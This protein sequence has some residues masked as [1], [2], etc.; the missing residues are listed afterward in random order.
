M[1]QSHSESDH[2]GDAFT[3]S[4]VP[5][6]CISRYT[7]ESKI[8]ELF[9]AYLADP[10]YVSLT[11]DSPIRVTEFP[12]DNDEVCPFCGNLN[13]VSPPRDTDQSSS[14]FSIERIT[15]SASLGCIGCQICAKYCFQAVGKTRKTERNQTLSLAMLDKCDSCFLI[16]QF[17]P[18]PK[19]GHCSVDGIY[20]YDEIYI[21]HS[22][23]PGC[24]QSTS[25]P[26]ESPYS[27]IES[28]SDIR[29][30]TIEAI[31]VLKGWIETCITSHEDCPS[32]P[33]AQPTRVLDV[34]GKQSV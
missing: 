15:R 19:I 13:G 16:P 21:S 4:A 12:S 5:E 25:E 6:N 9:D 33:R 22:T 7:L 24:Q 2:D 3:I 29:Q 28:G 23:V 14:R 27:F 32:E 17:G 8:T 1:M 26:L 18:Y 31:G 20:L 11:Q 34:E 10:R 30:S